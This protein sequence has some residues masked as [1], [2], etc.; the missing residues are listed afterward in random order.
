MATPTKN[1]GITKR[2]SIYVEGSKLGRDFVNMKS[3]SD[4]PTYVEGTDS[5]LGQD[6]EIP[7]QI[8]IGGSGSF[9]IDESDSDYC[10]ALEQALQD[11]EAAGQ[12]PD[13]VITKQTFNNSGVVSKI[14]YKNVTLQPDTS[15]GGRT[16]KVARK[17]TWRSSRPKRD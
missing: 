9:E 1:L 17:Y 3:F 6:D 16:E 14:K 5:Y 11:A 12:R 7:W 2:I 4:K 13:I 10:E 8:P 15:A